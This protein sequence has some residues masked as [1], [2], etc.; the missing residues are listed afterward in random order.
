MDFMETHLVTYRLFTRVSLLF[1]AQRVPLTKNN[2]KSI[3]YLKR[4]HL[5]TI[6]VY[7]ARV[8]E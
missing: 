2:I 6:N 5:S 8:I 3:V 7:I 4:N 1:V